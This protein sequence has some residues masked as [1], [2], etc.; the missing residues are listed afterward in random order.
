MRITKLLYLVFGIVVSLSACTNVEKIEKPNVV[1]LFID[2]MGYADPSCFGN[3]LIKT[4]NIDALAQNG[5]KF[6]NFYVNSPICSPSRVAINTGQYP[7]RHK[8]HSYINSSKANALRGMADFLDPNVKTLAKTLQA[9]GYATAHIGKWHLGGGRDV[10][11]APLIQEY[12]FDKSFTSFEGLGDRVLFN[13]SIH[14]LSRQ[15][16]KLKKGNIVWAD[17]CD[18]TEM[19]V[20]SALAFINRNKEQPF[21]L[22]LFPDDVHDYH[23]PRPETLE[24]YKSLTQNPWEQKFLA[25]LDEL[26][27]QIGRFLKGLEEM[28]ELENTLILFTSDNGPTDWRRYY[29]M[30]K[31]PEGYDGVLYAPGFAGPFH[32]RKWSLYEGGIRMPFIAQW[33]GHIKKGTIDSTTVM[34]AIDLYPTVCSLLGINYPENIDGTDKSN[35]LFGVPIKD[36]PPIMW[37]YGSGPRGS[38]KPGNKE[39]ISPTLAIRDGDWKLLINPDSTNA[40]LFNLIED[41]GE[42]TNLV[43]ENDELSRE[44][45]GK[46][47]QWR[48]SMPVSISK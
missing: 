48:K 34:S 19:Y 16:A 26:D 6:T 1:I 42:T 31:Y 22:H 41:P 44:L 18:V 2:D 32:G 27:T 17:K 29:E 37:E 7:M 33:A 3:P 15:S 10:D 30:E 24:K 14:G 36:V 39:N 23:L 45:A 35:A 46:L 9:N 40:K 43:D 12:G 28:N 47:I 38:I 8:I 25:V 4:P 21:F 11:Y 13:D 20:D 5:I